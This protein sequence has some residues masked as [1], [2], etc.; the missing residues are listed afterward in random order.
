MKHMSL[1]LCCAVLCAT[2]REDCVLY[3]LATG[4]ALCMNSDRRAASASCA[5]SI[6][7]E[8]SQAIHQVLDGPLPH[9]CRPI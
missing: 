9:P 7:S 4:E 1:V 3:Y 5:L 2:M 6:N 8:L